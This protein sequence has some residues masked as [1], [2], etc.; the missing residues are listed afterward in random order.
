MAISSYKNILKKE[1][2]LYILIG[3]FNTIFGFSLFVIFWSLMHERYSSF[4]ILFIT[5]LLSVT[6]AFIN[7]KAFVFR[8]KSKFFFSYIKFNIVYIGSFIFNFV[9]FEVLV[10][11]L[12]ILP[13]IAQAIITASMVF[14]TYFLHKKFSFKSS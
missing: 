12:Q 8:S 4:F 2:F 14:L 11:K 10:K 1:K 3:I 9:T 13:F 7:Y 6:L 5:H